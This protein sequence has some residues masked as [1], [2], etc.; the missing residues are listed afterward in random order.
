MVSQ[1]LVFGLGGS[2]LP[3]LQ[4]EISAGGLCAQPGAPA[5]PRPAGLQEEKRVAG[6]GRGRVDMGGGRRRAAPHSAIPPWGSRQLW[7]P[8]PSSIL[9]LAQQLRWCLVLGWG[10]EARLFL[11][12]KLLEG[13]RGGIKAAVTSIPV[14]P[15]L[16]TSSG[17]GDGKHHQAL[18]QFPHSPP[19][20]GSWPVLPWGA[21]VPSARMGK[22]W[23]ATA[24]RGV[25]GA[26]TGWQRCLLPPPCR[27]SCSGDSARGRRASSPW[28]HRPILGEPG[29]PL[30]PRCHPPEL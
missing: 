28:A 29:T 2:A 26:P 22:E 7:L 25:T 27:S 23:G 1:T 5:A 24:A 12:V 8:L 20:L 3:Q 30:P 10:G 11:R 15:P 6:A 14:V 9:A 17:G 16:P 18:P 21:R 19:E 4:V 13:S